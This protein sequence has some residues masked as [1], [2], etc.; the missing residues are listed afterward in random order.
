MGRRG[1]TSIV[2]EVKESIEAIDQIGVSKRMARK[3][4]TSGIHSKK[5]KEN[6]MSDCQNFVK[7]ARSTH[8]VKSI[9]QLHQGHY[10]LTFVRKRVYKAC[11]T[12]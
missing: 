2:R 4:G 7:W 3:E 5:Q 8:E 6:T 9:S 12:I 1:R 11:R 10:I